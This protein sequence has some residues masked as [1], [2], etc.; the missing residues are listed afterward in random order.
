MHGSS[1]H[2]SSHKGHLVFST[3]A[4]TLL[5]Y[6]MTVG[7]KMFFMFIQF[8]VVYV[9]FMALRRTNF[10]QNRKFADPKLL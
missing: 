6:G 1:V 5:Q 8:F 7:Y 10:S 9:V 2:L 4:P 3:E